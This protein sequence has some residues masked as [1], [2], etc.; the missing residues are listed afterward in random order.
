MGHLFNIFIKDIDSGIK[1][2]LSKFA[3]DAELSGTAD[4]IKG[5]DIISRN[6][7]RLEWAHENIMRFNKCKVMHLDQGNP[8]CVYSL[9]EVPIEGIP[10]EKDLKVGKKLNMSQ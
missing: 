5:R 8:R 6:L 10:V 1:C 3:D 4:I 9:G 2:T 7:Y